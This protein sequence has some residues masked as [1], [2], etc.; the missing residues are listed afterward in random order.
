M[1]KILLITLLLLLSQGLLIAQNT[2]TV[3]REKV[4][5]KQGEIV[6]QSIDL[7]PLEPGIGKVKIKSINIQNISSMRLH[8]KINDNAPTTP[9]WAIQIKDG[10]GKVSS[11]ISASTITGKDFWSDEIPGSTATVEIISILED[12]SS[13]RLE[14]KI[15][16]VAKLTTPS[17]PESITEP[18]QLEAFAGSLP[19]PVKS[20][21]KSVARLR[22]IGD[23]GGSYVCTGFLISKDLFMTNNHCIKT[24]TEMRS[25]LVDFD[26]DE[27]GAPQTGYRF[28]ELILT[29]SDLDFSLLRL[30]KAVP[31]ERG[32]FTLL[33]SKPVENQQLIIIQHPGG[34]PKKVS[35]ADCIVV[36][37]S[38]DGISRQLTDFSHKCDTK[39]GSSGSPVVDSDFK[40]VGL[41]HL[42]FDTANQVLVNRAVRIGLIIDFIRREKPSVL[43]ELGIPN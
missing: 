5:S 35:R 1:K 16:E 19:A 3:P 13:R 7:F 10:T 11:I 4:L 43:T 36:T 8:F 27:D 23:D 2:I 34:E 17:A 20:A 22:F 30:A 28:K 18:N 42:G 25:G 29:S 6:Q 39:G 26:F 41:H 40:V 12:D 15:F 24:A 37:P 21:G 31:A 32:F 14:L 38:I 9:S 33:S